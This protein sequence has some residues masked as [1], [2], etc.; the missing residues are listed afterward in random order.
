[1][2][3]FLLLAQILQCTVV[4]IVKYKLHHTATH[5]NTLKH[6][7]THSQR[8]AAHYNT[9]QHTLTPCNTQQHPATPPATH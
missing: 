2:S 5:C 6:T 8:T 4:R 3:L 9:L 7:A 1:M